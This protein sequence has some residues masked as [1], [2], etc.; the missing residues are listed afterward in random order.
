MVSAIALGVRRAGLMLEQAEL[1]YTLNAQLEQRESAR[2]MP[3][4]VLLTRL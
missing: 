4:D 2:V 1:R 3:G